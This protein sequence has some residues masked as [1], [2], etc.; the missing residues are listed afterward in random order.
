MTNCCQGADRGWHLR[1]KVG[2][3]M[4]YGGAVECLVQ[5][6]DHCSKHGKA[7]VGCGVRKCADECT[8]GGRNSRREQSTLPRCTAKMNYE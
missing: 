3:G 7:I 1:Q 5:Q 6:W 2:R 8:D 4:S